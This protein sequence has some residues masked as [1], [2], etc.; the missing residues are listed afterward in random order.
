MEIFELNFK[1]YIANENNNN[2]FVI[3]LE[4]IYKLVGFKQKGHAK[5]FLINKFKLN[6]HYETNIT[7]K[8]GE[9]YEKIML[10]IE[11]FK[12][13]CMKVSTKESEKFLDYYIAMENVILE[14]IKQK[15]NEQIKINIENKNIL[16]NKDK[17]IFIQSKQLEDIN[18]QLQ[19][20]LLNTSTYKEIHKSEYIYILSTDCPNTYKVDRTTTQPSLHKKTLQTACVKPIKTLHTRLT[21]KSTISERVIHHILFRYKHE[22]HEGE[23][24]TC[25]LS[26][27]INVVDISCLFIDTLYSSYSNISQE[28]LTHKLIDK[29][30]TTSIISQEEF[31]YK[32]I[33]NHIIKTNISYEEFIL[34]FINTLTHNSDVNIKSIMSTIINS[35]IEHIDSNDILNILTTIIN[36][37]TLPNFD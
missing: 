18:Q 17:F 36:I 22:H 32:I 5:R 26:Y 24:F 29:L 3:D 8:G 11:T 25:D 28:D 14:Y 13:F 27:I 35:N 30:T 12:K 34:K 37:N 20:Q 21:H 1:I 19:I 4:D 16:E 2:R 23:H 7:V 9:N 33:N 6:I 10:N 15:M 31:I